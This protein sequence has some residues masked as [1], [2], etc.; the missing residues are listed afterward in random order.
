MSAPLPGFVY[1]DPYFKF[2]DG[3]SSPKLFVVLCDSAMDEELSLITTTT[4]QPKNSTAYGCE[5]ENYPPCF[6]LPN[7]DS[8][9]DKD[10]WI[11]LHELYEY[12]QKN[13]EKMK[14]IASLSFDQTIDLLNCG[15]Q[16]L[17]LANWQTSSMRRE[18]EQL[19]KVK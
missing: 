17:Y 7:N 10:T 6:F 16:S 13:L 18:A 5:L 1:F 9:L 12:S 15:A 2:H 19:S 14:K 3:G 8:E 4:S 11:T